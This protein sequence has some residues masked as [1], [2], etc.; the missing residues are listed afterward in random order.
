MHH[1]PPLLSGRRT[2]LPRAVCSTVA[3]FPRHPP[4]LPPFLPSIACSSAALSSRMLWGAIVRG[5]QRDTSRTSMAYV[6]VSGCVASYSRLAV[7]ELIASRACVGRCVL[8][9]CSSSLC[10]FFAVVFAELTDWV[11][12][13]LSVRFLVRLLG[14]RALRLFGFGSLLAVARPLPSN[15]SSLVAL[16]P[17][18]GAAVGVLPL[19]LATDVCAC[20]C[21]LCS[22]LS[23]LF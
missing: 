14:L 9:W 7:V 19:F 11:V 22:S 17:R 13:F 4:V 10:S 18:L 6:M 1:Q 12:G 16:P 15:F 20:W 21:V 23:F 5:Q 8:T 3:F 2:E